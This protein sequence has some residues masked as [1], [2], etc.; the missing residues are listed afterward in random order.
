VNINAGLRWDQQGLNGNN[1]HYVLTGNWS[2]RFGIS[3]DPW[4]DRKTKLFANF[5]RYDENIPLDIAIRS[6]SG[7]QDLIS[8][9]WAPGCGC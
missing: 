3:V 5:G 8:L 7:E 6:L 1:A 9:R 4:G 2:P